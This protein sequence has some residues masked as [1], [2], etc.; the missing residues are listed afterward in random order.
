MEKGF[1]Y[2]KIKGLH[3]ELTT[4]CNA[5][6][7]MCNRNFKGKKREKL[8]ILELSI[9]DIK[10]LLPIE[11]IKKL[12]LVSLCGVYGD[13]IC[14]KDLKQII[15]YFYE[16][17]QEIDIDL[18]TNGS[19]YDSNWWIDLAKIMKKHRG[20]V[21]FG[22]DGIGET[23]SLHR[24][25]TN[26][27]KVINNARSYIE[28]GG[29][30]QWDFI[31]FK[32]NEHQVKEAEELSKQLG[33]EKFQIKKTSRFFKKIYEKD[34]NLDST[35][36]IYGKHPVYNNKGKIK[37]YIEMPQKKEYRNSS[38][39]LL[40]DLVNKYGDF[41]NY[42]DDNEINCESINSGGIFISANGEVFPC[43][44]V[45]QQICYKTIHEVQ[46]ISELNEYK[47]YEENNLSGYDNSIKEIVE[48]KFFAQLNKK[49][50]CESISKGKPKSCSRTCGRN[51]DMH[52]N[53]H[54]TNLKYRGD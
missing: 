31:V 36:A 43:C 44:T 54:T 39:D 10:K 8:A 34:K 13:P 28:A 18:Y 22:I 9:N 50:K 51:L 29:I 3:L 30:A 21:I 2:E 5:N 47:L 25:N 27:D 12:E 52:K 24:C 23:H 49:F 1:C 26:Y 35:M 37:Y 11:F 32:H 14:N 4:K 46:D 15:E 53:T 20:T 7:P 40:F 41:N 45:Y 33:F 38:E 6:C 42:L 19:L 17:N 16:C 48:G